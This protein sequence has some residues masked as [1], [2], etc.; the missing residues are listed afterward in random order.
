MDTFLQL[1]L[2]LTAAAGIT[3]LEMLNIGTVSYLSHQDPDR[4]Q[5]LVGHALYTLLQQLTQLKQLSLQSLPV[6]VLAGSMEGLPSSL[7]ALSIRE[8]WHCLDHEEPAES[9]CL[10]ARLPQLTALTCLHLYEGGLYPSVLA[11]M[12]QLQ[13]LLLQNC[14]VLHHVHA[15]EAAAG[16]GVCSTLLGALAALTD[17]RRLYLF[18]CN[19]QFLCERPEQFSALTVSSSLQRLMIPQDDTALLPPGALQHA[20]SPGR[21]LTGLTCL[22]L[23]RAC[24][25]CC[26]EQEFAAACVHQ[27]CGHAPHH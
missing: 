17:L 4:H 6:A 22:M 16:P 8:I 23:Q 5:Q 14:A 25:A 2:Q 9:P 26:A 15:A 7:Q 10:P 21:Q 11:D 24:T 13:D 12:P 3:Q 27:R 18:E 1:Q 20:F 19:T